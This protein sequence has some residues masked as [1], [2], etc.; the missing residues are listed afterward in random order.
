MKRSNPCATAPS[1]SRKKKF[2]RVMK[3]LSIMCCMVLILFA[4]TIFYVLIEDDEPGVCCTFPFPQIY[5]APK[6][7][8]G[9]KI[10]ID[11]RLDDAAW[12]KAS[13]SPLFVDIQGSPPKPYPR[14]KTWVKMRWDD[15]NLY[16]GAWMQ[17]TALWA[18][19]T[20]R[21]S[22]IYLDND[23]ELFVDPDGDNHWYKE[24]E[25]NAINTV[26]D[27]EMNKPYRDGGVNNNSYTIAGLETAIHTDG[28]ANDPS[29]PVTFW[30]FEGKFPLSQL[31]EGSQVVTPPKSKSWWRINFSRVEWQVYVQDGKYYKV[32]GSC[33]SWTCPPGGVPG[34]I[35]D[36]TKTSFLSNKYGLVFF[37]LIKSH[38]KS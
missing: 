11:G 26:W 1:L 6:L 2:S 18:N 27:L 13:Q 24:F 5:R 9:D 15:S 21:D 29:V 37:L 12:A 32:P 22:V 4:G 38:C 17:E 3:V 10:V 30:S 36:D 34:R 19:Q 20:E 35:F 23:F 31:A 7:G 14:F 16:V 25:V 28:V 33:T 8:S